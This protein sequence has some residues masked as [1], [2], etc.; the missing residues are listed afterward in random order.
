MVGTSISCL[1]VMLQCTII[2][3]LYDTIDDT[4]DSLTYSAGYSFSTKDRDNDVDSRHCAQ[5]FKGAWWYKICHLANLNGL[6]LGGPHTSYADGIEWHTWHGHEYSL[7]KVE[8]K[9]RP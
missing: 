7:K 2:V 5:E 8:M 4:G 6:Y 9:L 1:Y 3:D